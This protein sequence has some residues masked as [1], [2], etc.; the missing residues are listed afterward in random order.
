MEENVECR[1]EACV[2]QA[3]LDC[4]TSCCTSRQDAVFREMVKNADVVHLHGIWNPVLLVVGRLAKLLKLPYLFSVHGVLDHRAMTRVRRKWIKKR[5][6]ISLFGIRR[7]CSIAGLRLSVGSEAEAA[8]SWNV[9]LDLKMA[10]V[11][12]GADESLATVE[13]DETTQQKFDAIAPDQHNWGR[14]LLSFSRIHPEKGLDMLVKAFWQLLAHFPDAHLFI[15]G[16][17]ED[18]AI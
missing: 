14:T 11:P 2:L 15:T 1:C 12:N 9:G 3:E 8:Q 13:P 4:G 6:A 7:I 17:R 16:L 18:F 5:V 10:F